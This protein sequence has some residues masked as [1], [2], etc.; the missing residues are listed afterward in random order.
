MK[1]GMSTASL[2]NLVLRVIVFERDDLAVPVVRSSTTVDRVIWPSDPHYVDWP[3][4]G[5]R[6]D[7]S[8][9]LSYAQGSTTFARAT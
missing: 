7:E 8:A 2:L 6:L 3:P 1:G 9:V 4:S 5:E